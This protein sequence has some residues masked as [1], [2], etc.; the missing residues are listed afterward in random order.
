MCALRGSEWMGGVGEGGGTTLWKAVCLTSTRTECG[1]D[2]LLPLPS[3]T[4]CWMTGNI[5]SSRHV[6][7]IFHMQSVSKSLSACAGVCVECVC[8][9][10]NVPSLT[11]TTV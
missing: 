8:M 3:A 4:L 5:P 9:F 10:G 2:M 11:F 1:W 7:Y 6:P